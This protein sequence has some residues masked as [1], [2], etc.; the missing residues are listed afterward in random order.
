MIALGVLEVAPSLSQAW[1]VR[2]GDS[3]GSTFSK[4]SS[5]ARTPSVSAG[6][7]ARW[8]TSSVRSRAAATIR[9]RRET[10]GLTTFSAL[11]LSAARRISSAG[12]SCSSAL[13]TS[14]PNRPRRS[15]AVGL[16]YPRWA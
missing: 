16:L 2:G 11:S 4:A 7:R 9:S 1:R 10:P 3:A 12:S 15:V 6:A 13:S 8:V 14:H 5:S